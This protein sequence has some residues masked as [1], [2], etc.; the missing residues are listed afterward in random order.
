MGVTVSAAAAST[1]DGAGQPARWYSWDPIRTA[2]FGLIVLAVAVRA[3][4]ASRGFLIFDDFMLASRAME[5]KLSLDHLLAAVNE[6]V[7]PVGVLIVWLVTRGVGLAHW[8]YVVLLAVGYAV[9]GIA[10]YRLL[11]LVLRPGWGQLVPLGLLMFSP[12]T[13]EATSMALTGLTVLPMLLAMVLAIGAQV[14]YVR[15]RR[16]RH[17]VTLALSLIFGLLFFE[18]S[19]LIAPLIFLLTVFLFTTGAPLRGSVETARRFWPAWLVLTV[20][21]VGYLALYTSIISSSAQQPSSTGTVLTFWRQLVG[22][23]L[24]PGLFGGPWQWLPSGDVAP[25]AE[26]GEGPRW[27][28]WVA[29]VAVVAIT[30]RARRAAIRAWLLLLAY[31]L[32]VLGLFTLT[33]LSTDFAPWVGLAPRYVCD[34]VVV[35]ALCLGVALMGLADPADRQPVAPGDPHPVT[36]ARGSQPRPRGQAAMIVVVLAGLLLSAAWSTVR[37]GDLWAVKDGQAF[38]RTAEAELAKAPT[39]TVFLDR[40]VPETVQASFFY[41]YQ[42]YS[43]FFLPARRQPTIVDMAE[44]PSVF[45]DSGRIRPAWVQGANITPGAD[46]WC[47]AH[48]IVGG[49]SVRL[50]LDDPVLNQRWIV[51]IGYLGGGGPSTAELRLGYG[52]RSFTVQPGLHQI[53]FVLDGG[54]DAVELTIQNT[55]VWLCTNDITV[56]RAVAWP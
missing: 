10:F 21:S 12:L 9:L 20:V 40:P 6:H 48:K 14:R 38:L 31:V 26:P 19:L 52:R 30:V 11:R 47:K 49:G 35:A 15:T 29:L 50:P 42:M 23:T 56:G 54:G 28:S 18:K 1:I 25:L 33:R 39:G 44:H 32:L 34:V 53:F 46:P 16:V 4:V 27:L 55:D 17:L 22:H 45:D 13:L 43:R 2:A 36:P 24:L 8:P 41:P 7:M 51:R 3:W 37:F 5:S